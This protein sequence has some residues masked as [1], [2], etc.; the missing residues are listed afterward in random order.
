MKRN[1][2]EKFKANA[3]QVL[4]SGA[5]AAEVCK[6][7]QITLKQLRRWETERKAQALEASQNRV[8]KLEE[9]IETLKSEIRLLKSKLKGQNK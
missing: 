5:S 6:E 8:K 7:F 9:Q 2:D 4:D 3:L 1:F